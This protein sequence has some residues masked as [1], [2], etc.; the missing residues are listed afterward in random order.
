MKTAICS[1]V[2]LLFSLCARAGEWHVDKGAKNLVKFTSEVVVLTFDGVTDKIDGYIYWEGNSFLEKN[3]RLRF[4]VDLNSIETGIGKR[5]RDMRD[6]LETEK[7][8][9][10]YFEGSISGLEKIDSTVTAYRVTAKGNMF[11]HGV[12]KEI[13]VPGTIAFEQDRMH[14]KAGLMILLQDYNI[15]A[16]S[17]AAFI[18]VSQEVRL[19]VDFYLKEFSE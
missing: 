9:V 8:P 2:L 19:L 6:V 17:L 14:I 5:D 11:I 10:T 3:S 18:K 16:P 13:E 12:V 7:W 1:L 15:E 4:E